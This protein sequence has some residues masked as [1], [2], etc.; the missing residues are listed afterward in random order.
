LDESP[1]GLGFS[2]VVLFRFKSMRIIIIVNE[3]SPY[4]DIWFNGLSK[5]NELTVIYNDEINK[6]HPWK[7]FQGFKGLLSSEITLSDLKKLV[8]NT[9]MVISGGWVRKFCLMGMIYGFLYCKKTIMVTDHPFHPKSLPNLFKRYFLYRKLD[10]IFCAT[11]S[12]IK[13]L[14]REFGTI[15]QGKLRLFPYGINTE[16]EMV[17]CNS[18]AS[19]DINVLIATNFYHR[20]GHSVL[21]DALKML[22]KEAESIKSKYHFTF[23]GKGD[24]LE[25]C[26]QIARTLS[27]DTKFLGWVENDEYLR[28]MDETDVYIHP[29]IEEPFGIPPVDAM[30]KGKVVIV[31]DGVMSLLGLIRQGENGYHY[32]SPVDNVEAPKELLDILLGLDKSKFN[33]IGSQAHKDAVEKF[34][35][36]QYVDMV[37]SL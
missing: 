3:P 2:V 29:S 26:Q 35:F 18:V 8:K 7:D 15:V 28:L 14:T 27:I 32:S 23:I 6:G 22:D 36:K 25:K 1:K 11:E 12:T 19:N 4:M 33:K 31:C 9:D 16:V 37:N 21:F 34:S 13:F 20:K 30:C 24:E 17:G 10:Y 5:K